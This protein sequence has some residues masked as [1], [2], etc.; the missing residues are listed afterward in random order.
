[1]DRTWLRPNPQGTF[2][3]L[4]I[5]STQTFILHG[6]K[7]EINGR[8][9]YVV[10]NVS[11]LTP[12]TALKLADHFRNGFH[13]YELN[14]F[15]VRSVNNAAAYGTYVVTGVHKGWREIVFKNYH[16]VMDSWHLDGFRF[17]VA[18]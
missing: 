13:V 2:N 15:P 3:V 17:Y 16:E 14:S 12:D 6:S 9:R 11:H 7:A 18:G 4:N 1:M 5:I 8:L 10:N